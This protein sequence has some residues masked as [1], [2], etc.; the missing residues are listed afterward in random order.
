LRKAAELFINTT[1][2]VN[3]VAMLVGINDNKYFREQFHKLFGMNPSDYIKKFRRSFQE[4]YRVN[5]DQ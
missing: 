2:N 5:K 3:E 4:Q 1:G